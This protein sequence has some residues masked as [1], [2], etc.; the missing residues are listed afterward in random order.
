VREERKKTKWPKQYSQNLL[1][2]HMS[3]GGEE[4]NQMA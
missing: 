1:R 2:S 4:E 3:E